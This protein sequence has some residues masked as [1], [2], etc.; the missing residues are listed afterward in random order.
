VISHVSFGWFW[1]R[2]RPEGRGDFKGIARAGQTDVRKMPG[3]NWNQVFGRGY[4]TGNRFLDQVGC[5]A[6]SF[7]LAVRL[8]VPLDGPVIS[9]RHFASVEEYNFRVVSAQDI[10][11]DI[12]NLDVTSGLSKCYAC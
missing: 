8:S 12:T 3:E 6:E 7:F 1:L 9:G 11:G 2:R 10:F 4:K 5:Y